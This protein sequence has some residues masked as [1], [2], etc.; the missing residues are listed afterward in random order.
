V[1]IPKTPT[2]RFRH[3]ITAILAVIGI[4]S[5]VLLMPAISGAA[6]TASH[7]E[8]AAQGEP[9]TG[10]TPGTGTNDLTY[11]Q[12]P[13][14][15]N[16]DAKLIFEGTW[17][18][19]DMQQVQQYFTDV[20]GSSFEG[21]LTQ[22]SDTTGS[23]SSTITVSGSVADPNFLHHPQTCA[24]GSDTQI[25]D[26]GLVSPSNDVYNELQNQIT[27]NN[28]ST[29]SIF[30]VFTPPGADIYL[31]DCGQAQCGYH[32]S[33]TTDGGLSNLVYAM[34]AWDAGPCTNDP[35]F[36]S[37][38]SALDKTLAVASHEQFEAIT[39]PTYTI[40]E[41]SGGGWY[42][43]D[44]GNPC[45]MADK[46]G[47]EHF[48]A[49]LNG[50]FY[51]ALQG[52]YSNATHDCRYPAIPPPTPTPTPTRP[53]ACSST[54]ETDNIPAPSS[55]NPYTDNRGNQWSL[56]YD[57][58]RDA[59]TNQI[60]RMRLV[61]RVFPPATNGTWKGK[62]DV[63]A[64]VNGAY[65]SASFG[66]ISSSGTYQAHFVWRGPWFSVPTSANYHLQSDE[67]NGSNA[68]LRNGA[69]FFLGS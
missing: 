17:T 53:P 32:S 6:L 45:E 33:F 19:S 15:R 58:L 44:C 55:N 37:G 61:I 4:I 35:T 25:L 30:F 27:A 34:V 56:D 3:V 67:Y 68:Y 21:L 48:G 50:H 42:N 52:E 69:D 57:L 23:I 12:G 65:Q 49:Y 18:A 28:W 1:Y 16:P 62:V 7:P 41:S 66:S 24:G 64:R 2:Q 39:N 11:H 10:Y 26:T 13:V 8:L 14:F 22:Y 60:C 9:L 51:P 47:N 43:Q 40:F 5:A 38:I 54:N 59:T 29:A 36:S 46:C 20:S 63:F 31:S